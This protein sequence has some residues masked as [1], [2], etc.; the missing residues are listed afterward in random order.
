MS[1]SF[2][3]ADLIFP[4]SRPPSRFVG[5]ARWAWL[6]WPVLVL[7]AAADVA[8][9]PAFAQP[10]RLTPPQLDQLVAR[11]ALYPD[12]LLA[13]IL[14]ASTYWD[15]IPEA[16]AW[17]D[18]HRYLTGDALARAIQEDNLPWHPSV[19]AL[20][21][22]PDVLDMMARDPAWTQQL[23]TAVLAQH[24][25]VMDAIQRMRRQA[26][27]F[28]YLQSNSYINVVSTAGYIEIL[29]ANPA[30]IYVPYY[31]PVILFTRPR[32]GI[33]ISGAIRFGPAI[34]IG[35]A[36]AT[37]GWANVGFIWPSHTIIIDRHPWERR[38]EH[39]EVYVHPYEHRWV[40]PVGP[41]V[42]RHEI[43]RRR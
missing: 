34:T 19:L 29:P 25:D 26:M 8:V 13:Q 14:T 6:F 11:I 15:E 7:L 9:V 10:V 42:E 43:R 28:G 23:G 3:A 32:P 5:G 24:Q 17:A 38:W 18:Q 33:E 4:W 1:N 22:F 35:A 40:R 36:F 27:E 30:V 39:R 20:L 21:P 16:A 37:W 2:N 31:D 41:R 12:P